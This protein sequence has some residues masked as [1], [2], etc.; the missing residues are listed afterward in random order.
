M[1]LRGGDHGYGAVTKLLHWLTVLAIATQFVVGYRMDTDAAADRAEERLDA[2]ED[3]GEQRAESRGE[4]AAE[5]FEAEV[6]RR[7]AAV[8]A[9]EGSPGSQELADVVTGTAFLDGVS[10]VEAHVLIGLT[11]MALGLVRLT[12]RRFSPLPPWAA[13]LSAAERRLESALEK[14]LLALLLLVPGTGLLLV[15]GGGGLLRV[16][17]AAQVALLVVVAVHV[18]LVLKHTVVRRHGHLFRML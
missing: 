6:E 2:F 4:A 18:G 14:T 16:H 17:V 7:E 9:L 5:R 11:V 8:D 3:R 15:L 12:W 1:E 13:H 10:G